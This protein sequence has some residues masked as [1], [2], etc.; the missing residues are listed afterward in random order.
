MAVDA[1]FGVDVPVPATPNEMADGPALMVILGF[2]SIAF[3][4]AG[5]SCF[6]SVTPM[7][8]G[9]TLLGAAGG[10]L[11]ATGCASVIELIE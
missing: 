2:A 3:N 8:G 5:L 9:L 11:C 6:V 4:G 7:V 10:A 1:L